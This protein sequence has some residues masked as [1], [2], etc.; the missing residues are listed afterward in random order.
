LL[1]EFGCDCSL[2]KTFAFWLDEFAKGS[3]AQVAIASARKGRVNST[4]THRALSQLIK[5]CSAGLFRLGLRENDAIAIWLPNT[6]EWLITHFAAARLGIRTVPINTW[7]RASELAHFLTLETCRAVIFAPAYRGIDFEGILAEATSILVPNGGIAPD[8]S[9]AVGD[10]ANSGMASHILWSDLLDGDADIRES[11]KDGLH[12][13]IGFPTSG[14]TSAPKLAQHSEANLL[15]HAHAVAQAAG[16]SDADVVL[17]VL[18]PCG[19]YGHGLILAAMAGGAKAI[20]CEEFDLDAVVD[21]IKAERVTVM[22]ITEP[23][24]RRLLDHPKVSRE[25]FASIRIVFSAGGSLEPVVRRAEEAF[26]F[27]ITNVYGS[28]EML[29]LSAFWDPEADITTRAAAGGRLTHSDMRVRACDKNQRE[30]PPGE[31]GE[32]QFHGPIITV[33]Y[34]GQPPVSCGAF[35]TDGWFRSQDLG[36]VDDVDGKSFRY[37]SRMN[38]VL[39]LKGFLVNPGEIETMLQSHPLVSAAQAVGVGGDDGEDIAV[40]FVVAESGAYVEPDM[41]AAYCRSR[42]A[43]YKVPAHI[44]VLDAFP[45][46]RSANGDKVVKHQLR[47]FAKDMLSND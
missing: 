34:T 45:L 25:T 23:L 6:P 18:P 15:V 27:R 5:R 46:T 7:S 24:V 9:I 33:G 17:C 41:L 10:G 13:V 28:S 2:P 32:L 26:G 4:L 22:A 12:A 40:A 19:A 30:L 44:R 3:A 39:R 14:T 11:Q 8:Y 29:A 1:K 20:L 47:T 16:I 37:I 31:L 21:L 43:A 38:D 35:G 36:V 42:M